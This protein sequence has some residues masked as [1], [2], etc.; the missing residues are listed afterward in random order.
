[1]AYTLTQTQIDKL[2][3]GIKARK[4]YRLDRSLQN[5]NAASYPDPRVEPMTGPALDPNNGNADKTFIIIPAG[6]TATS[7]VTLFWNDKIDARLPAQIADGLEM[8]I[9]VPRAMVIEATKTDGTLWVYYMVIGPDD[10]DGSYSEVL[11]LP[12]RRYIPPVYPKPEITQATGPVDARVLDVSALTG[13][14]NVTLAEWPGQAIGDKI[15]L[16]TVSTPPIQL[17][18]WNPLDV[19][20]LGDQRRV[21]SLN[22][23]K[24][25][26]NGSTLTLK[27][28]ASLGGGPRE[29]FS[30][31][32]FTVTTELPVKAVDITSVKDSNNV[33]IPNGGSTTDTIVTVLGKVTFG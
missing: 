16:S 18:N 5:I 15:W 32:S 31:Q 25:L 27:L 11:L 14:A 2:L 12:V 20:T 6:V 26:T 17:Q 29:D 9:Q 7:A 3:D 30:E 8:R 19:T 10:P 33:E 1:M 21:I 22:L 28:E 13:N 24:T 4:A 23:L